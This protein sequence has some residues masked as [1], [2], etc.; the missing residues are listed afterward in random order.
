MHEKGKT[1]NEI[2]AR[3]CKRLKEEGD[4]KHGKS[5]RE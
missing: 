5:G 3:T 1:K 4:L 2:S